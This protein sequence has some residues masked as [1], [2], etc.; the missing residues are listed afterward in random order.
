M[1]LPTYKNFPEHHTCFVKKVLERLTQKMSSF[2]RMGQ[3]VNSI[4]WKHWFLWNKWKFQSS[5]KEKNRYEQSF[6]GEAKWLCVVNF[7]RMQ[8]SLL[9]SMWFFLGMIEMM[10]HVHHIFALWQWCNFS[11]IEAPHFYVFIHCLP[12]QF[13]NEL[14]NTILKS[15]YAEEYSTVNLQS[16]MENFYLE[17]SLATSICYRSN[18]ISG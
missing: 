16:R 8:I 10:L 13:R 12:N 5:K 1:W 11:W 14:S 18:L 2:S 3:S 17:N 15:K 4:A 7:H 9:M 6:G